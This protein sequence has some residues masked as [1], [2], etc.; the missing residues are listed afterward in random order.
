MP[1]IFLTALLFTVLA[2]LPAF[3]WDDVGHKITAY[4]AWQRMTPA[5]RENVIR[6][7]RAAPEDAQLSPFYM[8]YGPE[9]EEV[10]KREFF[11]LVATWADIVRDRAFENRYRK[12]HHSNWHYSDFFWRQIDG[13]VV[14]Q[15]A[16]EEGGQAIVKLAEFD[17]LLRDPNAPNSDKAVAIAWFMHLAGDIH[18][19]LHTSA[20]I[21]DTEPKG[22]QGGN[23]FHLT[24]VGTPR[25]T[26]VNIHWFWDSIV[27]RNDPLMG[28][29]CG[30]NYIESLADRFMKE[31][32]LAGFQSTL[33]LGDYESWKK[34]SFAFNNTDVFSA[35]LKRNEMPSEKYKK[36]AYR[37]A[38][39]QLVEAGYRMGETFNAIFGTAATPTTTPVAHARVKHFR[40]F[41]I[42]R[43]F[44]TEAEARV[45]ATQNLIK[46]VKFDPQ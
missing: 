31:H 29:I 2:A 20:R 32:P 38:R 37:V 43:T 16:P 30:R 28:E 11:E 21:T 45:F 10:R 8:N 19:P 4:I 14:L 17:K 12:Y 3:A 7:L 44:T 25:E 39:R 41:D 24:P 46:D 26:Q 1:K 27:G 40:T 35:E 15:E 36:N 23:L 34:E 33:K 13:K 9:P 18:Q 5:A 22:D 42:V 6:I